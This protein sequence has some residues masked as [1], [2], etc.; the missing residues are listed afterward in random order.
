[1]RYT[2]TP[3]TVDQHIQLLKSRGLNILDE[4]RAAKYLSNIG[5][6]RLSGYMYHLQKDLHQF[7]EEVTFNDV[8]LYYKFDKELRSLVLEYLERIEIAL[9]AKL[10]DKYSLNHGFYWYTQYGLYDDK[11]V[12]DA[13][14]EKVRDRFENPQERFLKSFKNKYTS[15]SLPP[16]NMAMEVLTL[17][18]L[19]RLYKGLSNNEEKAE[20]AKEFNLPSTILSTWFMSMANVRN[21]CAHHSRLWN[22]KI[23]AYPPKIPSRKKYQFNGVLPNDFNT[24]SYGV[25]S[26]IDRL[27]NEIN[28]N[29]TFVDKFVGL[30]E[31][32]PL[33]NMRFMGFPEDWKDNPAWRKEK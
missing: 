14:N 32:Y 2:K 20:I 18:K 26:M 17:G 30:I 11:T 15:E 28:S 10:N 21:I 25:I 7:I 33:V 16:S 27:L 4:E 12:Y 19:S 29:N 22:R 13:I 31:K 5:Y 23:T 24:T 9:R 8:I 1:M 3:F 6:F